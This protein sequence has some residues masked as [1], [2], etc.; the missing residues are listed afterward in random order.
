MTAQTPT[1][2]FPSIGS[3][4]DQTDKLQTH[5]TDASTGKT[6]SAPYP[7]SDNEEKVVEEVE[8]LCMRCGEQVGFLNEKR[9]NWVFC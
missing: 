5:E 1:T 9:G 3:V 4:A 7:T 6:D 8:S 2:L